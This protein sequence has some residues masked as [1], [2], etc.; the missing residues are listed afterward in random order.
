MKVKVYAE[1]DKNQLKELDRN[2]W[3]HYDDILTKIPTNKRVD[4]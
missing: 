2:G 1:L 3:I 4:L